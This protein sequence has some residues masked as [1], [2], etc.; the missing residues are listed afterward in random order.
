MG[1]PCVQA[2]SEGEAQASHIVA[3]GDAF[4]VGSQDYDT[5][6]FGSPILVRN[7]TTRGKP[8][9]ILLEEELRRLGIEREQLIDMA[10]LIGTDFNEG[11]KGVGPK[12]ALKLARKYHSIEAILRNLRAEIEFEEVKNFFLHPDV[13]EEYDIGF[14]EAKIEEIKDFLCSQHDFALNRVEKAL[15]RLERVSSDQ[16]LN[17]WL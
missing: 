5:L 10:I 6:L 12:T 9:M 1:I 17:Q 11:I 8:E 16:T 13:T 15:A 2:P 7:L 3:N 4:C 14:K